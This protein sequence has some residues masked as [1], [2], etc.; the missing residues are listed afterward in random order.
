MVKQGDYLAYPMTGVHL[1]LE[2]YL[3]PLKYNP[4]RWFRPDPVPKV[5]H[6]FL[7]WGAG[8]HPCAGMKAFKFE[9]KSCF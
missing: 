9:M 7:G 6:S 4:D 5:A 1:N 2:Y 8:Q 3:E